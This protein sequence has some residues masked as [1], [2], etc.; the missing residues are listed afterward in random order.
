[1]TLIIPK[2]PQILYAPMLSTFGGGSARGFN[3][4]G[5]DGAPALFN[6]AVNATWTLRPMTFGS[7]GSSQSRWETVFGS[8]TPS[9]WS[10]R[11]PG[12]ATSDVLT[13]ETHPEENS[14]SNPEPGKI[15]GVTGFPAG[16]YTF[17]L[18]GGGGGS[19][20]PGWGAPGGLANATITLSPLDTVYFT[21]GQGGIYTGGATRANTTPAW[22][23]PNPGG[24]NGGGAAGAQGENS[25]YS[26]SGG[27]G[28]DIRLNGYTANS[29]TDNRILVAGGGGGATDQNFNTGGQG[30]QFNTNGQQGGYTNTANTAGQ[31]GT[32]TA[33]GAGAIEDGVKYGGDGGLWFGG[34]GL[35]T[36]PGGIE[37]K[38]A[39]GGGGGGYYGGGGAADENEPGG[40]GGAGGGSGYADTSLASNIGG[41][42]GGA[43]NG[44][45]AYTWRA[46][47]VDNT[48]RQN[49][50]FTLYDGTNYTPSVSHSSDALYASYIGDGTNTHINYR[51]GDNGSIQVQ[52]IS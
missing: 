43:N 37:G 31:G 2:K 29:T 34:I 7:Y 10:N 47:P 3:P 51:Y 26:G 16:S 13:Y 22:Y 35:D 6:M 18:R 49:C 5:G 36:D 20:D 40:A 27:G 52:R 9:F 32:L 15:F 19:A 45:C 14:R 44:A 39:A 8:A 41:T 12:V 17:T 28:T 42:L 38:N 33:G 46:N 11:L 23:Y 21:I 1:M 25:M 30:A 24:W 4:G 48:G 50:G